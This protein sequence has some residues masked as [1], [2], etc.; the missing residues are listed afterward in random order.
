M[1][2]K[3]RQ[4]RKIVYE[5]LKNEGYD[6]IGNNED[7]F[8]S[9]IG[10][11]ANRQIVFDALKSSGYEDLGNDVNEFSDLILGPKTKTVA[12]EQRTPLTP[13]NKPISQENKAVSQVSRQPS[14]EKEPLEADGNEEN[15]PFNIKIGSSVFEKKANPSDFTFGEVT[16]PKISQ[17]GKIGDAISADVSRNVFDKAV[18]GES[19][20]EAPSIESTK[21]LSEE[22][23]A[24][25]FKEYNDT[26]EHLTTANQEYERLSGEYE[27]MMNKYDSEISKYRIVDEEGKESYEVP[28]QETLEYFTRLSKELNKKGSE[29]DS[30]GAELQRLY[31]LANEDNKFGKY[32]KD[33]SNLDVVENRIKS[34][35]AERDSSSDKKSID[36]QISELERERDSIKK[37]MSD[38]PVHLYASTPNQEPAQK[39]NRKF[40]AQFKES[41][42]IMIKDFVSFIGQTANL[43]SGTSLDDKRALEELESNNEYWDKYIDVKYNTQYSSED[44]KEEAVRDFS[45]SNLELYQDRLDALVKIE[46][47]P[48]KALDEFRRISN[49]EELIAKAIDAAGGDIDK[50]KLALESAANKQTW[51]DKKILA[52][53]EATENASK[54]EG[55]LAFAGSLI[56]QMIPTA[57]AI[58]IGAL[59]KNP[60][61]ARYL[62]KGLGAANMG[63]LSLSTAGGSMAEAVARGASPGEVWGVG[64]ADAFIEFITEK[65]PFDRYTK[66]IFN[67]A[68]TKISKNIAKSFEEKATRHELESLLKSANERLGGKLFSSKN[69]EEYLVSIL[70][71]GVSELS[72]EVLETITTMIYLNPEEYPSLYEILSNGFQGMLGGL[73]MGSILGGFSKSVEHAQQRARRKAQGNVQIAVVDFGKKDPSDHSEVNVAEIVGEDKNTGRIYVMSDGQVVDVDKSKILDA[74]KFTFDEFES[75]RLMNESSIRETNAEGWLLNEKERVGKFWIGDSQEEDGLNPE[76]KRVAIF[77]DKDGVEYYVLSDT[78]NN[79]EE[80]LLEVLLVD[81]N[82]GNALYVNPD[83]IERA[84]RGEGEGN[85]NYVEMPMSEYAYKKAEEM[86]L[87][88]ESEMIDEQYTSNVTPLIDYYRS[89]IGNDVVVK[90]AD[91]TEVRGTVVLA[92]GDMV[93]IENEDGINE[94]RWYEIEPDVIPKTKQEL[95]DESDLIQSPSEETTT[96]ISEPAEQVTPVEAEGNYEEVTTEEKPIGRTAGYEVP[97]QENGDIDYDKLASENPGEFYNRF[98]SEFGRD[99]AKKEVDAEIKRLQKAFDKAGRNEKAAIKRA[100]DKWLGVKAGYISETTEEAVSEAPAP[101][102]VRAADRKKAAEE[103][104]AAAAEGEPKAIAKFDA[105]DVAEGFE[106]SVYAPDGTELPGHW[107]YVDIRSLTPSH[108]PTNGFEMSVGAAVDENGKSVN[109][110]DYKNDKNAQEGV[111]RVA[112]DYDGRAAQNPIVLATKMVDGQLKVVGVLSGNNRTMSRLLA[113][114]NGTDSKYKEYL[115]K[116]PNR[117]VSKDDIESFGGYQTLVFIPSVETPLTPENYAKWNKDDKKQQSNTEAAVNYGK[118][119]SDKAVNGIADIVNEF[120]DINAAFNNEGAVRSILDILVED[121][122]I[123]QNQLPALMEGKK[124][125]GQGRDLVESALIGA[126]LDEESIR[127]VSNDSNMRKA[128]VSAIKQLIDISRIN[129]YELT[130]ELADSIRLVEEAK[131]RGSIKVN[132]GIEDYIY[133]GELFDAPDKV[134]EGTV[135]MLSNC[136]NQSAFTKL[137]KILTLYAKEAKEAAEG[138]VDMFGSSN[139]QDILSRYVK[140]VL[141]HDF[142]NTAEQKTN[143]ENG[144]KQE[145][146]Q[147]EPTESAEPTET[148]G[149]EQRAAEEVSSTSE[150]SGRG[151]TDNKRGSGKEAGGNQEVNSSESKNNKASEE[152]VAVAA[153]EQATEIP[154]QEEGE[155]EIIEPEEWFTE[156]EV[157]LINDYEQLPIDEFSAEIGKLGETERARLRDTLVKS[158]NYL[159]GVLNKGGTTYTSEEDISDRI[160]SISEKIRA[161]DEYVEPNIEES[162]TPAWDAVK[163]AAAEVM[164]D[165]E[166]EAKE[167]ATIQENTEEKEL[168]E[169]EIRNSGFDDEDTIELAVDYINGER[170]FS[171]ELSYRVIKNYVRS[172]SGN[173]ASDSEDAGRTQLD[174]SDNDGRRMGNR[175][176]LGGNNEQDR[177]EGEDERRGIVRSESVPSEYPGGESG[178]DVPGG[179][180]V[181]VLDNT[182]HNNSRRSGGNVQRGSQLRSDGKGKRGSEGVPVQSAGDGATA[183]RP[184]GNAQR[185]GVKEYEEELNDLLKQLEDVVKKEGIKFSIEQEPLPSRVVNTANKLGATIK[186]AAAM[187][188]TDTNTPDSDKGDVYSRMRPETSPQVVN[189]SEMSDNA[190]MLV[191]KIYRTAASL[192]MSNIIETG[193]HEKIDFSRLFKKKF[194]GA[195]KKIGFND[196]QILYVINEAWNSKLRIGDRRLSLMEFANEYFENE[197][198]TE[199]IKPLEDK[200]EKQK[201]AP[202]I[203]AKTA[204]RKNI[205]EQLPVLL[206]GQWDD[207]TKIERQFFSAEHNDYDHALG[208]GFIVTNGTGTGK[209]FTGLG[210]VKR[211]LNMGKNRILLVTPAGKVMDTWIKDAKNIFDIEI[212]RLENMKDKGKG[213]IITSYENFR[214]N[215]ALYEDEFD[216]VVYDECQKIIMAQSGE[217]TLAYKAHLMITNKNVEEATDRLV[218]NTVEGKRRNEILDKLSEIEKKLKKEKSYSKAIEL[219]VEK[220][221]LEKESQSLETQIKLLR[222][223]FEE[224]AKAAVEKTKVLFLSATPF[225]T[226][227]SLKIAEGYAFQYPKVINSRGVEVTDYNSR[228]NSFKANWF[229]GD[230]SDENNEVKFGDHL[231]EDLE[232]IQYRE[233]EN[234]FDYSRDFPDVSGNIMAARFNAAWNSVTSGPLSKYADFLVNPL[235]N[236]VLFETMRCSASFDRMHEHLNAGRKLVL[237]HARKAET[238]F[239]DSSSMPPLGPPFRTLIDRANADDE[240]DPAAMVALLKFK[241]EFSDLLDWEAGLDYRPVQIQVAEHF[242]T[243][244]ELAAYKKEYAE[245]LAKVDEV[246]GKINEYLSTHPLSDIDEAAK[247]FKAP[248]EPTLKCAMVSVYNGDVKDNLDEFNDDNSSKK[249]LCIT[250]AAGSAGINLQDKTGKHPRVM[251]GLNLPLIPIHF[252]QGEGRIYRIG[253]M[254]NAIFEYP[255]LGINL[256]A[257]VFGTSMNKRA[258]TV[259]NL[260]HGTMGRGLKSSILTQFYENGGNVPIAG[261]GIGGKE[262]DRRGNSLKGMEKALHDLGVSLRKG[263]SGSIEAVKEPFG[264]IM[265][266]LSCAS[267]GDDALVPFARRGSI[268]RYIPSGVNT[269]AL[270]NN[271]DNVATLGIVA[272]GESMKIVSDTTFEEL[273]VRN[274][275]D[276]V[277]LD[278]VGNNEKDLDNLGKAAEHLNEGGRIVAVMPTGSELNDRIE[279][280][281]SFNGLVTRMTIKL[282]AGVPDGSNV[283]KSIVVI[284]KITNP[285]LRNPLKASEYDL[286]EMDFDKAI[287]FIDM[288][289]TPERVIDKEF[290]KLKKFKSLATDLAKSPYVSNV[291]SGVSKYG[292]FIEID[293]AKSKKGMRFAIADMYNIKYIGPDG[294]KRYASSLDRIY[295]RELETIN[296]NDDY[297]KGYFNMSEALELTDDEFINFTGIGRDAAGDNV[298]ELRK[299]YKLFQKLIRVASGYSESQ[300]LR[301][302]NGYRPEISASD[303]EDMVTIDSLREKFEAASEGDEALL[304]LFNT[305]YKAMKN[306]GISVK[307]EGVS[308]GAAAEY[309]ISKHSL[310]FDKAAWN[311][312]SNR[313]RAE[314]TLHEMIHSVTSYALDS[315]DFELSGKLGDA[316]S[317]VNRIYKALQNGKAEHVRLVSGDNAYALENTHELCANITKK[318]FREALEKRPLWVK[319]TDRGLMISGS[320]QDGWKSV[321]A[322]DLLTSAIV[323]IA[324]NI[325]INLLKRSIAKYGGTPDMMT[326]SEITSIY[327]HWEDNQVISKGKKGQSTQVKGTVG[328][329]KKVGNWIKK[330]LPANT[331]ILDASSGMGAGTSY[332]RGLGLNVEDVEP[333]PSSDRMSNYPPNYTN[334]S[335]IRGSYDYIISNAVLNVVPD[336]VRAK[337]L[338]N[339][340]NLLEDGG[341]MFIN[342][343]KA[344]EEKNIKN[345]IELGDSREVLVGTKDKITSYQKFFTTDELVEYVRAELGDGYTVE[346]ANEKNS[347]TSGLAAVVVTKGY[348]DKNIDGKPFSAAITKALGGALL[349][350]ADKSPNLKEPKMFTPA[351]YPSSFMDSNRKNAV[352]SITGSDKAK[353]EKK[354]SLNPDEEVTDVDSFIEIDEINKKLNNWKNRLREVLFDETIPVKSFLDEV[355][356]FTGKAIGAGENVAEIIKQIPSRFNH[357]KSVFEKKYLQPIVK[358]TGEIY[359]NTGVSESELTEYMSLKHGLERQI[360]FARRDSLKAADADRALEIEK[361]NRLNSEN[362]NKIKKN[363][364][365]DEEA[366]EAENRR[367]SEALDEINA[368]FAEEYSLINN[369]SMKSKYFSHYR[370]KEYGA[371]RTWFAKYVDANGVETDVVPEKVEGESEAHYR[372]RLKEMIRMPEGFEYMQIAE[373]YARRRVNELEERIDEN[374]KYSKELWDLIRGATDRN[375]ELQYEHQCISREQYEAFVGDGKGKG[376]MFE[377]YIPMRGFKEDTAEDIFNYETSKGINNFVPPFVRAGGRITK[378]DSPLQYIAAMHDSSAILAFKNDVANSLYKFVVNHKNQGFAKIS[379]TW[380]VKTGEAGGNAQYEPAYPNFTSEM[381]LEEMEAEQ[382]RF[383]DEMNSLKAKGEAFNTLRNLNLYDSVVHIDEKNKSQHVVRVTHLGKEYNIIF[384]GNP[385]VAQMINGQ[386]RQLLSNNAWDTLMRWLATSN[387]SL[388]PAFWVTNLERDLLYGLT[389]QFIKNDIKDSTKYAL[390]LSNALRIVPMYVK[391]DKPSHIND[392]YWKMYEEYVNYGAPTGQAVINGHKQWDRYIN[393]MKLGGTGLPSKIMHAISPQVNEAIKSVG[394]SVM[395]FGESFEQISRF[396]AYLT[397]RESGKT[398]EEA[399][400]SAKNVTLNFNQKGSGKPIEWD[401]L[402]EI[403]W[404][405]KKLGLNSDML[406]LARKGLIVAASNFPRLRR[407]VLFYNAIMQSLYKMAGYFSDSTTRGKAIGVFAGMTVIGALTALLRNTPNDWEDE[408]EQIEEQKKNHKWQYM[409][410]YQRHNKFMLRLGKDSQMYLIWGVPQEFVPFFGLGD[411]IVRYAQEIQ[412]GGDTF[413]KSVKEFTELLPVNPFNFDAP[414]PLQA[415]WENYNNKNYLGQPVSRRNE[416]NEHLP[417]FRMANNNTW[418]ILV[419]ASEA[420]NS[421]TGGTA[422]SKGKISMDPAKLQNLIEGVGG[423][424]ITDI[425]AIGNI[426]SKLLDPDRDIVV[427]DFPITHRVILDADNSW[428]GAATTEQFNKFVKEAEETKKSI[429]DAKKNADHAT[430]EKLY[431]TDGYLYSVIYDGEFSKTIEKM[432]DI[433]NKSGSERQKKEIMSEIDKIRREFVERCNEVYFSRRKGGKD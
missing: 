401:E 239:S 193:E 18:L 21:P 143:T 339:M 418:Q 225:H 149:Q 22:Q 95:I 374:K 218:A 38:N 61:A 67:G 123:L 429:K 289:D 187:F 44:E 158:I 171:S 32:L 178:V 310:Y 321:N 12:G 90:K 186:K 65:I 103:A 53:I 79:A 427:R 308:A 354:P 359:K 265:S 141:G 156:E 60:T 169:D 84:K 204:D 227:E 249:V 86:E 428:A 278:G 92:D 106:D 148:A 373:E 266:K 82:T 94:V 194:S 182:V 258:E 78:T 110:T 376:R 207:V 295:A 76:G 105:Y 192:G 99:A 35:K 269:K 162:K 210:T 327:H 112:S 152:D 180:S 129:G 348:S 399:V 142:I 155:D 5:A 196:S 209:T 358:L 222:P 183:V 139:K 272:S 188:S 118:T 45:K 433:Y 431:N 384:N 72:A 157:E 363:R 294:R 410:D 247:L 287:S 282:G 417:G 409:S 220:D 66:K 198:K 170:N 395:A 271:G 189:V 312:K 8:E 252:I 261:Q 253:N 127:I 368:R 224:Q 177:S 334:Y 43:I 353:P 393:N 107:A 254:S 217:D 68:K 75:A 274:K 113:A 201:K 34:L 229:S 184:E 199:V 2:D 115:S 386:L 300:L 421:L 340:A 37:S 7:E 83:M 341:R 30:A 132:E 332:L 40:G 322:L 46:G 213:V 311:K 405:N 264:Y 257:F 398:I 366:L 281:N 242:A 324:D 371:I 205:I 403:Y 13:E 42:K 397:A 50:A 29:L 241:T 191:N 214:G 117:G 104:I 263:I 234:G 147:S 277:L 377:Y 51:G 414:A 202:K 119:I 69:A 304:D 422:S 146:E 89:Q 338:H 73:F 125:S 31:N 297:L 432:F 313:E 390:N 323:D 27:S 98:A 57:A 24:E 387:T 179:T 284:D 362:I 128:I 124:L 345:R 77:T 203:N 144:T 120:D 122:I 54:P 221:N 408:D 116:H 26:A 59:T 279:N 14:Q 402:S 100:L 130:D 219:Q 23:F 136:I 424:A 233:L 352:A 6:D 135:I 172:K 240:L 236:S 280:I 58:A 369:E 91:G 159:N 208:K 296:Q 216:L 97:L 355:V 232:T 211:F 55:F 307:N 52:A 356:K 168:T 317:V 15:S 181:D 131:R 337:L 74:H 244:E 47:D 335:D 28:D 416:W 320:E 426:V 62:G 404:G 268:A 306:S 319:E 161:I 381:T 315:E 63:F 283:A 200:I 11:E 309:R 4:N 364:P 167:S 109:T 80:T 160:D 49:T 238:K 328:T 430:L 273:G 342:T 336:D 326:S 25:L 346:K 71:D 166:K 248:K 151:G 17:N 407:Y 357:E 423:G 360:V 400:S 56:P 145:P 370:Q 298:T 134:Y 275:F 413:M 33:K 163:Q 41:S 245:W 347:G 411:N 286:S 349:D 111:K 102:T 81:V 19:Q 174:S 154:E 276:T 415:A 16:I 333:Y 137:K 256:E 114:Q 246:R 361:E 302:K 101:A 389:D 382:K 329:Y 259:E 96:E 153:E 250:S 150:S 388:R 176:G 230:D 235:W 140:Q 412:T 316:V 197:T 20:V 378:P 48:Q 195:L 343:R 255:R 394:H 379:R 39:V 305:V 243:P 165:S 85:E 350:N 223:S 237:F 3:Y 173:S 367:H 270:E 121:G 406:T 93:Q 325:D 206:P 190:I 344:G 318:S 419:D 288:I 292:P 70:S 420:I 64:M 285:E 425:L 126:V 290:I 260:A 365:G 396:A 351:N 175:Q 231:I 1:E 391:G 383:E 215:R 164:D 36:K 380:F 291:S 385:R 226:I 212:N 185:K 88:E 108:D 133:Q 87:A 375:I 392:Y 228:F 299:L 251:M 372:K 138:V 331:R 301:I 293:Y 330:Y 267:V 9:L 10:D 314:V 262:M 303:I